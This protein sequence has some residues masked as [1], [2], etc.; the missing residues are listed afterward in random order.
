VVKARCGVRGV[1]G[2][3]IGSFVDARRQEMA[4][5]SLT[6]LGISKPRAGAVLSRY[7]MDAVV[8]GPG[9]P[10]TSVLHRGTAPVAKWPKIGGVLPVKVNR[11]KPERLVIDWDAL[12]D[13]EDGQ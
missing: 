2:G 12:P 6:V 13:R 1:F 9:I 4:D 7:T 5:G 11:V 3:L 10:A 8:H